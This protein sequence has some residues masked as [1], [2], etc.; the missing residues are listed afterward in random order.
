MSEDGCV[1]CPDAVSG[2]PCCIQTCR[3]CPDVHLSWSCCCCL[4]VMPKRIP[5][6][7]RRCALAAFRH[8]VEHIA[9][10]TLCRLEQVEPCPKGDPAPA[11]A[12]L[13]FE[14]GQMVWLGLE[15]RREDPR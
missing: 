1:D 3:G 12:L 10:E 5:R 2:E 4:P 8:H 14:G 9:T 11:E 15:S 7:I 6:R 13:E